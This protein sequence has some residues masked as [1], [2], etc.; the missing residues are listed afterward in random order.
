MIKTR[1]TQRT[2]FRLAALV[3]VIISLTN[4]VIFSVLFFVI[5]EQ[6]NENLKAHVNEVRQTLADVEV[7][8]GFEG[9]AAMVNRHAQ[10]AQ[11]N[12]DIYLLTDTSDRY[13]AGNIKVIPRFP[14]WKTIAW[15]ELPLIGSWTVPRASTAVVGRWTPVKNGALFVGD[16]NGDINDAQ[17]LLLKGLLWGIGLSMLSAIA[18]G[19]ILG[20]SAQKRIAR[21]EGVL[22]AVASG[23]LEARVPRSPSADD[24]DHVAALINATLDRLQ[25]LIANLRQV[26]TDIAHDLRTPIA[27]MRQK[28]EVVQTKRSDLAMYQSAVEETVQE[29]D[30]ISETFDALLRISEI[31]AGARKTKFVDVELNSLL[32]NIVDALEAVADERN[33]RLIGSINS[34]PPV[35]VRGDRKLLNQLFI[36]LIENA[37]VHCPSG[38]EIRVEL[39]DE[40]GRPNVK[41]RD[42]GAGIPAEEREKVFRRLYRLEKSRSTRGSGLGLSLVLAIAEL[43]GAAVTLADNNPGL[44][45]EVTFPERRD[46]G[47]A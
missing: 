27:R 44:I 14:G 2:A 30:G 43:H 4:L 31:E 37:I 29:I 40:D 22:G 16:G 6:L 34:S 18:G 33:H 9:L 5:S 24:L 38:T 13:V 15:N 19:Y 32:I 10:V 45:V 17:H 8:G 28:L 3:A 39:T 7:S 41:V 23:K 46:V 12:E 26:S 35:I 11:S 1:L 20:L 42:T 21:M 36:N 25:A 47:S